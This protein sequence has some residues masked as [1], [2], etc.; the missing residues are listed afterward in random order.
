MLK[1]IVLEAS[2]WPFT[3]KWLGS[4]KQTD[5]KLI[6]LRIGSWSLC[7]NVLKNMEDHKHGNHTGGNEKNGNYRQPGS[8]QL[9]PGR[10]SSFAQDISANT[11]T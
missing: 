10:N 11:T 4:G 5:A 7:A 6:C 3:Q 2:F 8:T 9:G 1:C